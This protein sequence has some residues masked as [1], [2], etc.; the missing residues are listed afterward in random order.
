MILLARGRGGPCPRGNEKTVFRPD[1]NFP[2][3]DNGTPAVAPAPKSRCRG[4][5]ETVFLC[6]FVCSLHAYF[7]REHR[8]VCVCVCVALTRVFY[9]QNTRPFRRT[10][11]TSCVLLRFRDSAKPERR[12]LD[13][14]YTVEIRCVEVH[15]ARTCK[16]RLR[17]INESRK[18]RPESI[19]KQ[20]F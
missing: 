2:T 18:F 3:R 19:K 5:R 20:V 10:C 14:F 7:R 6:S 4:N 15:R 11:L 16:T 17:E 1:D 9:E 8:V 13:D 12:V